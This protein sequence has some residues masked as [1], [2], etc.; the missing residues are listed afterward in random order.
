MKFSYSNHAL[1]QIKNRHLDKATIDDSLNHPD[2]QV[3]DATGLTV[4]HKLA[5][6]NGK[7][8]LY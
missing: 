4:Y 2:K 7:H 3:Q 5:Q 6:E 1:E 8:Y